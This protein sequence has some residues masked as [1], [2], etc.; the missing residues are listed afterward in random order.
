MAHHY[1]G[2]RNTAHHASSVVMGGSRNAKRTKGLSFRFGEM[3]AVTANRPPFAGARCSSHFRWTG[4]GNHV[5][6]RPF[7]PACECPRRTD[8]SF[9]WLMV[10]S[11]FLLPTITHQLWRIGQEL[12]RTAIGS[13]QASASLLD[14]R[15]LCCSGYPARS[16]IPCATIQN[17]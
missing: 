6:S 5:P 3:S 13:L 11:C 1:F 4:A 7:L 10:R 8:G 9:S 15:I 16:Y 14:G 12:S 17:M 2:S